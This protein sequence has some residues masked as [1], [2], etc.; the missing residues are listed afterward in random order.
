MSE[1]PDLTGVLGYANPF[2]N[3]RELREALLFD[4][5]HRNGAH[6]DVG[7]HITNGS[8]R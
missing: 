7:R 4:P 3:P 8:G 1:G 2:D 6:I 5:A